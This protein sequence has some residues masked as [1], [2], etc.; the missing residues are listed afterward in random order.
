MTTTLDNRKQR[1]IQE[2]L[3]L[4]REDD[5]SKVEAQ[6]E[7]IQI[8]KNRSNGA[9]PDLDFYTGNIEEKVDIEKISKE[10]NVQKL[11]MKE[12]N[13]MIE[14]ADFQE[15]INDLLLALK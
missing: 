1:L 4:E 9:M 5:V 10:Q 6:V 12:L 3:K 14:V 15:D 8:E 2:I 7:A 11:S 13:D